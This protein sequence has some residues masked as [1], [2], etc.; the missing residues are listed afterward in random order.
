MDNIKHAN[1]TVD[2]LARKDHP[3]F[4]TKTDWLVHS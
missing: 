4:F 2:W 1:F 3:L